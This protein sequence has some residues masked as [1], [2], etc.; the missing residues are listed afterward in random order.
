TRH[1]FE[2]IHGFWCP[3]DS[4]QVVPYI[5]F[6]KEAAFKI[7]LIFVLQDL[8]A[9]IVQSM[10]IVSDLLLVYRFY[11]MLETSWV[12]IGITTLPLLASFGFF[13]FALMEYRDT[14]QDTT[15]NSRVY[16]S[17]LIYESYISLGTNL[18][19]STLLIIHLWRRKR[20]IQF[21]MGSAIVNK[22]QIPYSKLMK[23]L[24]QSAL[25]PPLLGFLHLT[26]RFTA[27]VA[28]GNFLLG[29]DFSS[30]GTLWISSTVHA[31]KF[32][33][34]PET[35]MQAGSIGNKV[36]TTKPL[37]SCQL[38]R[39]HSELVFRTMTLIMVTRQIRYEC[40]IQILIK[41]Q[42]SLR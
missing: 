29:G 39:L 16:S 14:R 12:I 4:I 30:I 19:V 32:T 15:E 24:F 27:S 20:E 22:S 1:A 23:V 18:I 13:V 25:P 35:L 10:F 21:L 26:L 17:V 41:S 38:G 42:N 9:A 37:D 36:Q 28:N 2:S 5:C 7:R 11:L 6:E 8:N 3:D 33:S 40:I 31:S 34:L